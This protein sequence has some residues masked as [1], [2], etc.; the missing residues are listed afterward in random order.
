MV[1]GSI[2]LVSNKGRF[3]TYCKKITRGNLRDDG[4]YKCQLYGK[5]RSAHIVIAAACGLFPKSRKHISVD[6]TKW[7]HENRSDNDI[8]GLEL[9]T[10]S[11]QMIRSHRLREI[12]HSNKSKLRQIEPVLL[13]D[14]I[15]KSI[16]IDNKESGA[17]ASNLGRFKCRNGIVKT[18]SASTGRRVEV[19][20]YYK[21]FS[22][23]VLV[24][25][26]FNNIS[27][28]S[29]SEVRDY[30][31]QIDHSDH[32]YLN[33][34]LDNLRRI[35]P[36][37]NIQHAMTNENRKSNATMLA[38]AIYGKHKDSDVW[39]EYASMIEA[40]RALKINQGSISAVCDKFTKTG[41]RRKVGV[42][43][44]KRNTSNDDSLP[45]EQWYV[46]EQEH[47]I[48]YYFKKLA[49]ELYPYKDN[50]TKLTNI[51]TI[52]EIGLRYKNKGVCDL[53]HMIKSL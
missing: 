30:S 40:A 33:N 39:T 3:K 31:H 4:Y 7:G 49:E 24:Y 27:I 51:E 14:E 52:Y 48:P 44:F 46:H 15:W 5:Q 45:D 8:N 42:Y 53:Y 34:R 19:T 2:P 21:D 41:A 37:E 11:E 12:K 25:N 43:E 50:P 36:K 47:M 18:P 16:I 6:H 22:F 29:D 28:A 13:S 1:N 20:I 26:A 23:H 35:T 38:T 17:Y 9:I 32:N 10:E